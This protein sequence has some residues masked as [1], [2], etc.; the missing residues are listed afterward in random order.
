ML[1][2]NSR[3]NQPIEHSFQ[4]LPLTSPL[5]T[6]TSQLITQNSRTM[7]LPQKPIELSIRLNYKTKEG[8][9]KSEEKEYKLTGSDTL[10]L[11][12]GERHDDTTHKV[13]MSP[14]Y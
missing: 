14:S 4:T 3:I 8:E 1:V 2:S 9:L 5:L 13:G 6:E 10:E 12:I 7:D 11:K